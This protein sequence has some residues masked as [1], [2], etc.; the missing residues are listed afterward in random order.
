[1]EALARAET[2]ALSPLPVLRPVLDEGF[3]LTPAGP[4]SLPDNP[5]RPPPRLRPDAVARLDWHNDVSTLFLD[6]NEALTGAGD[7]KRRAVLIRRLRAA[8]ED[9]QDSHPD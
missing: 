7:E 5:R 8:L 6:L 3:T 2:D 1:M 4:Q 9:W